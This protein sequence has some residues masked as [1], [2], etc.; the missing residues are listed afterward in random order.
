[1]GSRT[2][3]VA[4]QRGRTTQL[5]LAAPHSDFG[6]SADT[7]V[8]ST[9]ESREAVAGQSCALSVPTEP[10]QESTAVVGRSGTLDSPLQMR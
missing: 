3:T 8:G 9:A 1:M 6:G 5:L 7:A 10:E 4:G 2:N